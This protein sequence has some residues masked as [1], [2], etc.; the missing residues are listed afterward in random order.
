[1]PMN[2]D[3][4]HR[5]GPAPRHMAI[6]INVRRMPTS[7]AGFRDHN[8]ANIALIDCHYGEV[9]QASGG[10]LQGLGFE[11]ARLRCRAVFVEQAHFAANGRHLVVHAK[12]V[13]ATFDD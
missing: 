8:C 5:S 9:R 4:D 1:M 10:M 6:R 12:D 3:A 2:T 13:T 11:E 7:K